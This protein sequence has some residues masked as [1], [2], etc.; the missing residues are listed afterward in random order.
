M[1]SYVAFR[2]FYPFQFHAFGQPILWIPFDSILQLSTEHGLRIL[3][4][5]SFVYASTI[6]MLAQRPAGLCTA[7]GLCVAV[8][9]VGEFGQQW[10]PG[11]TPDSLDVA[12]AILAGMA[13]AAMT[14]RGAGTTAGARSAGW[15]HR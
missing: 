6:W 8:L 15:E 3:F 10:L 5:K 14:P 13:L 4:E 9:A 7:T 1:L 2:Q 11:R 12:I